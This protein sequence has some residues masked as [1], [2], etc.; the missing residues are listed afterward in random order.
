MAIDMNHITKRNILTAAIAIFVMALA[1]LTA[2]AEGRGDKTVGLRGGYNTHNESAV[3]GLF[4][5]YRFSEHFRLSPLV[6]YVFKHRDTD[7]TS[8]NLNAQ[9]PIDFAM[10]RWSFYPFAGVNYT[11]W[12]RDVVSE[13]TRIRETQRDNK[14]GLNFG[15]GLEC[16]VTSTLKLFV[17]AK[18]SLVEHHQAGAFMGGIGYLF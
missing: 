5:Q 7:A 1:P 6:E 13:A 14:F 9:F 15:A 11:N 12:S 4:F 10:D 8:I 16:H 2:S 17:E 18:Y 3:A